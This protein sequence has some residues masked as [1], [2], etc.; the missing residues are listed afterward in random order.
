MT[1]WEDGYETVAKARTALCEAGF[2]SLHVRPGSPE[3]WASFEDD[4]R[5]VVGSDGETAYI[6]PAD[7]FP[8][9]L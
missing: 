7:Y 1:I 9:A 4:A 6:I 3:L 8:W 2:Y 5:Y